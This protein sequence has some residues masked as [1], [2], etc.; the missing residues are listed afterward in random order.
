MCFKI[1]WISGMWV[2]YVYEFIFHKHIPKHMFY[3]QHSIFNANLSFGFF[4]SL[5]QSEVHS[6]MYAESQ[7]QECLFVYNLVPS[8][9]FLSLTPGSINL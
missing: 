5:S 7:G 2:C 9:A 4:Y 3:K 1:A 6:S 8:N